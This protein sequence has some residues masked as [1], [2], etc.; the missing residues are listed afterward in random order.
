MK[1]KDQ[2]LLEKAYQLILEEQSIEFY[3]AA[4][5]KDLESFKG[6]IRIDL[7]GTKHGGAGKDQGAG[8][9]VFKNKRGALKHATDTNEGDQVIVVIAR[10][11]LNAS[12]FDID[13]EVGGYFVMVFI[14]HLLDNKLINPTDYNIKVFSVGTIKVNNQGFGY[15]N[16]IEKAPKSIPQATALAAFCQQ[17]EKTQ[18][19]L[20]NKF[21]SEYLNKVS[22]LKYN[23]KE[24]I[25]PVRIEDLQGN[26]LWSK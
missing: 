23:G 1:S 13:Y 24:T 2:L 3:H 19:E 5:K 9:Y 10:N 4:D 12:E 26:I 17:L 15:L 25:Y 16:D 22:T 6:G 7:A 8:F 18:P 21:E 14:K 11:G 20:F